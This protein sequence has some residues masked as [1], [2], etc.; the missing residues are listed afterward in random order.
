M[1][2]FCAINSYN[3]NGLYFL[4][5]LMLV[6][7]FCTNFYYAFLLLIWINC[8]LLIFILIHIISYPH[9]LHHGLFGDT[10]S[11]DFQKIW[12]CFTWMLNYLVLSSLFIPS[13]GHAEISW[14]ILSLWCNKSRVTLVLPS[15]HD[16]R[17]YLLN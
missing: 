8:Y 1:Y 6:C 13:I 11:R 9:Q 16:Y 10:E 15:T 7:R 14:R 4:I 12:V 17:I 2:D 3:L 5:Y